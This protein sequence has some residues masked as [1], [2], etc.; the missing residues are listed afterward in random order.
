M[1]RARAADHT[2]LTDEQRQRLAE[3]FSVIEWE[4]P[5]GSGSWEH[6]EH[7]EVWQRAGSLS[8]DVAVW[9]NGYHITRAR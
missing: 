1:A 6:G 5:D 2:M 7:A 8:A 4:Y 9:I 3:G